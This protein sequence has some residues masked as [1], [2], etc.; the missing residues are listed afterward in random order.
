MG[1]RYKNMSSPR[2]IFHNKCTITPIFTER[3]W[4]NSKTNQICRTAHI[5]K[6]K[7]TGKMPPV[8]VGRLKTGTRIYLFWQMIVSATK[9]MLEKD[10]DT[11]GGSSTLRIIGVLLIY[12][13]KGNLILHWKQLFYQ[14]L[15]ILQFSGRRFLFPRACK[16]AGFFGFYAWFL[17]GLG[18]LLTRGLT[19]L[20]L[21]Y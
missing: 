21:I 11:I 16:P 9:R 5:L 10:V 1:V 3:T 17:E 19:S 20:H 12:L 8:P 18:V 2:D 14:I 13:T 6:I 7:I 15:N 4:P